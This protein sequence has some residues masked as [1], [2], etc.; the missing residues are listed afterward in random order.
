MLSRLT[1]NCCLVE[2]VQGNF[3]LVRFLSEFFE[4]GRRFCRVCLAIF[5]VDSRV[6]LAT[7]ADRNSIH[8]GTSSRTQF[9][10]S[11]SSFVIKKSLQFFML[12]SGVV[13]LWSL[14]S[15]EEHR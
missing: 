5:A 6:S 10:F 13:N 11:V 12:F 2:F 9:V 7:L 3:H 8:D 4:T 15:R 14:T 1:C